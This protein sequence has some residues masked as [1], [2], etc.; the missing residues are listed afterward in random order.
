MTRVMPPPRFWV[1]RALQVAERA[2]SLDDSN[3]LAHAYLG[4]AALF[5]GDEER[6]IAEMRRAVELNPINPIVLTLLANYLALHG[7]L[8]KAVSMA[9]TAIELVPYPPPWV[10]FPLFVDHYVH[11]RYE[12]ALVHAKGGLFGAED[13]R[14]PLTLA[15][16]LGQL[17]RNEEAAPALEEF[18]A[19]WDELG[20]EAGFTGLDIGTV[21]RELLERNVFSESLA[22]QLIEGL[23]KA[24]L[25]EANRAR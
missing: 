20:Q 13:F 14:D 1:A 12:E 17:G 10:D 9:G 19:L 2:V 8:D 4:M 23:E 25:R 16:T 6:G 18:R 5:S 7:E 15:A 24:G 3:Q 21:R 22:D 11:G